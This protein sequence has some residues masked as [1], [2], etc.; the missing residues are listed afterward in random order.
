MKV[1]IVK[2]SAM[3]DIIHAMTALQFMKAYDPSMTIDWIVEE[4]FVPVLEHNPDIDHILPMNLKGLKKNRMQFLAEVEK[5]RGYAKNNYDLVID[6]QGLIKSAVV[7]RMLGSTAGFDRHS[8]RESMAA[9]FYSKTFYI[10][11]ET[12]V[13]ERNVKLMMEAI[14]SSDDTISLGNKKPF[15]FFADTDR[16]KTVPFLDREG[17]NIVYIL[18][19]SWES[20]IY[21]REKFL[22]VVQQVKGNHLLVWG[23]ENEKQSAEYIAQHSDAKVLPELTLNELKALIASSNLVIGGDSG[24]T[25]MAWALNRPSITLFGPTPSGRNTLETGINRIVDCG[26]EIDPKQLDRSDQ[27]IADIPVKKVVALAK[28]LCA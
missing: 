1:A 27:C 19:S 23:N 4:I 2:L 17:K 25:H 6:A 22:E 13:I 24:P 16:Q 10:P 5:V 15:L 28:E 14:G 7:S 3:G 12:N 9:F 18:G 11:Y 8:I 26:K 21:P 20:K